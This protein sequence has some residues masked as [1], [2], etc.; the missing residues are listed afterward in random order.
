MVCGVD[1]MILGT[2]VQTG[3]SDIKLTYQR[4]Q[5]DNAFNCYNVRPKFKGKCTDFKGKGNCFVS[6]VY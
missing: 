3:E 6:V 2:L 5:H 4:C 1:G